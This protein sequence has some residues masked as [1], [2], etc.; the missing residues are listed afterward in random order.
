[1]LAASDSR[2]KTHYWYVNEKFFMKTKPG[3]KVFFIPDEKEL[4]ITCLDDKGRDESVEIVVK[5]Y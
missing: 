4:K 1:L 5:Y 2:V 3:E